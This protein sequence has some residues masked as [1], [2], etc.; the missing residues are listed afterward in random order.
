MAGWQR[1]WKNT[2]THTQPQTAPGAETP[3]YETD[4]STEKIVLIY[5]PR[6]SRSRRNLRSLELQ[7]LITKSQRR[8]DSVIGQGKESVSVNPEVF[9]EV[10][11]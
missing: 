8:N 3:V 2:Y 11:T 10:Y 5:S 4:V 9:R 6:I 7:A 1:K